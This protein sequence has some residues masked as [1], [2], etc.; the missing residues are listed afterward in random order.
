M[1]LITYLNEAFLTQAQL[2][3]LAGIDSATLARLQQRSMMPQPSYRLR[4]ELE[5]DSFF[6]RHQEHTCVHY[7]GRGYA[8]WVGVLHGLDPEGAFDVFSKRYRARLAQLASAGLTGAPDVILRD[9]WR[10]FLDGTYGLCTSS[11]LPEDIAAK[12]LAVVVINQL[13]E[14]QRALGAADSARLDAAVDLL[15]SVSARFAPHERARSSRARLVD[16][17][18]LRR[19]GL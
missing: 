14:G 5:C 16:A 13:G 1:E 2:L 9:E 8:S 3:T 7:Y 4:L 19:A 12:E 15:D 6:G 18:R 11:G 17:V 10:H